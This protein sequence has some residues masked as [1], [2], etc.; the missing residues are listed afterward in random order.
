MSAEKPFDPYHLWLGIAPA[1]QP[2]NHY[3]L[4]GTGLFERDDEVIEQAAERQSAHVRTFLSTPQVAQAK[5]LLNKIRLATDC[6]HTPEL[7]ARYDAA[8]KTQLARRAAT[9]AERDSRRG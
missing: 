8:L 6:L 4:L 1:D 3:Q 7:K 2:P 9:T 5:L